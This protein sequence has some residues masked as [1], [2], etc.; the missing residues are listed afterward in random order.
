SASVSGGGIEATPEGI[1][2]DAIEFDSPVELDSTIVGKNA[3]PIGPD[4]SGPIG[5]DFSLISNSSDADIDGDNNKLDLD[6]LLGP[7]Q[8][9]GGL[10]QT[11]AILSG[12]PAINAGDNSANLSFDQRGAGF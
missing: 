11:I 4:V 7:L 8:N 5:A 10:T 2:L 1:D 3:A 6:P 12:S 9:N